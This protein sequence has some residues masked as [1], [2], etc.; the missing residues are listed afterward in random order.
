MKTFFSRLWESLRSSYWFLP[1]IMSIAAAALSFLTV[2]IDTQI[3]AKWARAAGWIWAGGPEGA[4]SVLATIAGSTITVAGVVFSITIVALTLASSQFGP[5][6]LR[7]FM[8]DRSTQIVL[9]VFVA[10]FLYSLLILRTIRGTDA[11]SFVPFLSVTCGLLFAVASVGFLI[12]FIHHVP[13]SILAENLIARVA[14]EL[15]SKID[16]LYPDPISAGPRDKISNIA[17]QLP[18]GFAAEARPVPSEE[19]GFVQAISHEELVQYASRHGLVIQLSR[20]AGDFVAQ[21]AILALAWPAEKLTEHHLARINDYF[22]FGWHRTPTQDVE[23]AID[24]LV[25]VAVRALSPGI[26]DPFTA[27]SCLEWLGVGLIQV[28]RRHMPSGCH[29]DKDS[30]LRLVS[31]VTDY[32]GLAAAAL[33]QIRQYG[34][35]SMAVITRMLDVISRVA[36]EIERPEDRQVLLEHAHAI[37]EDGLK[38]ARNDRDKHDIEIVYDRAL[39]ALQQADR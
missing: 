8:N 30:H 9:G 36:L 2:H 38:G 21:D 37:R 33:N 11:T 25:E 6:L 13:T 17:T 39:A 4:R 35:A 19:S 14:Q 23:Y 31:R 18:R 12:F 32:A 3:N 10:T 24:Q 16:S 27:M 28:G 15:Q 22:F 29:Y 34:F 7:N 5:R 1:S 20:R 26:N